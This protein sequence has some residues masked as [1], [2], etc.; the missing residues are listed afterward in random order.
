MVRHLT[1][2]L[3]LWCTALSAQE[4]I[5]ISG[6]RPYAINN[7][8]FEGWGTALCWWANRI[9]YSDTLSQ[10]AAELFY[11]VDGL[12]MNIMRF[13]IGGG[14]NP[15]HNHITRTDS[16]MPG[17]TTYTD[18]H[19]T[20]DWTTDAAQRNV[21]MRC[22]EAARQ[23]AIVEMFANSAPYYMTVS[24]CTS[25]ATDA[26]QNNLRPD[27][28]RPFADYL[29]TVCR[30]YQDSLGVKV[31][32]V[33]PMNEPYTNYWGAF[34]PK[35]EGCHFDQGETMNRT[36]M[37]LDTALR[38]NGLS[39]TL[40]AACDES[41]IDTQIASWNALSAEAKKAV[42]RIDTHTYGGS[43]RTEMKET[44]IAAQRNLWMSEVDGGATAGQDAGE[45]GAALWLAG[46]IT[47]DCNELQA[48]AWVLWQAIDKHICQAGYKGRKDSGMIDLSK[49]YWG[50]AVC[51]HDN[52]D[53]I[54]TKKYYAF[55]QFSR[56]LRPGTT[57]LQS[58]GNTMAGYDEER[59]TLTIVCTNDAAT[60][61][62]MTIELSGFETIGAPTQA[63]RTSQDED[64]GEAELPTKQ[65][66]TLHVK[67]KAHS[68]TTYMVSNTK[69]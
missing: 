65:D 47:T 61:R 68:I 29:A 2:A 4:V 8:R 26:A 34:S 36:I 18:G 21:L 28:Y 20:Y 39:E 25:G 23:D 27:M 37:A 1:T 63:I 43:K 38:E 11:G 51:D 52:T 14:D 15:E 59:Q 54:L 62:E 6:E 22:I 45:M 56:H 58:T 48:S 7:G 44:A 12:Q 46:R 24:G 9:G 16:D 69:R 31:Q 50:L 42:G 64:W 33:S 32:S 66:N 40:I 17:Y 67:L 41:I 55:G 57:M 60:E 5:S 49:G 35:Q 13:N 53:I 19:T 30:Y 10:R 3:A